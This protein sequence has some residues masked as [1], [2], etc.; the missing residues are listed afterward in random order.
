MLSKNALKLTLVFSIILITSEVIFAIT[1]SQE[2]NSENL[3]YAA[4][5]GSWMDVNEDGRYDLLIISS[6]SGVMTI[7]DGLD[8][9]AIWSFNYGSG[10]PWVVHPR[11]IDGDG[12]VI[13]V[14]V[15]GDGTKE[16]VV[17]VQDK[18]TGYIYTP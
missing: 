13:P 9:S 16:L 8:Y 15:D 4:G 12:R 6:N 14:D 1:Y 3:G 7:R 10:Y 11:D 17:V 5:G 18:T 2:W